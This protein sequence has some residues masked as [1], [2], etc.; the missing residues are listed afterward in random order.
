MAFTYIDGASG[1]TVASGNSV[2]ANSKTLNIAAHDV[3][4]VIMG[5]DNGHGGTITCTDGGSNALTMS[6]DVHDAS[7]GSFVSIGY[8]LDAA[9]N[10]TAAFVGNITTAQGGR[11][12]LIL[13]FRPDSGDTISL[14]PATSNP[15]LAGSNAGGTITSGALTTA[16]TDTVV[17][18]FARNYSA[19]TWSAQQIGGTDATP[20]A[21]SNTKINGWYRILTEGMSA[22]TATATL[23]AS[24]Y[25]VCGLIGIQGVVEGAIRVGE[26]GSSE[27]TD[28]LNAVW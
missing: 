12:I 20:V 10:A 19:G 18:G 25:W 13:Q 1:Y 26:A 16:G 11:G 24:S 3:L 17:A 9:A 4:V 5:W 15:T 28:D 7:S 14:D 23:S 27:A 2:S 21:S 22:G 6:A 8:L